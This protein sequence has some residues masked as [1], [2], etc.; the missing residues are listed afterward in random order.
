MT[1]H[2]QFPAEQT[3]DGEFLRQADA[4]RGLGLAPAAQTRDS[5]VMIGSTC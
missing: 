1:A 4:F 3:E 2:A 5:S